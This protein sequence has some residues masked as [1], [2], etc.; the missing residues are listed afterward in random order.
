[1]ANDINQVVM[2]GNLTRD[3][4]IRYAQ[5]GNCIGNFSLAVNR[6]KKQ[7]DKWIEETSFFD[8]S[9]FGKMAESLK[10]YLVRGQKVCVVGYLKQDRWEK[11]GKNYSKVVIVAEN[12]QLCGGGKKDEGKGTFRPDKVYNSAQEALDAD[13]PCT[14]GFDED[15]PF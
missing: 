2:I 4:E 11:D 6:A 7:G 14:S 1:M 5:N 9:L 10:P 15:L 13:A 12:I 8:V 3:M